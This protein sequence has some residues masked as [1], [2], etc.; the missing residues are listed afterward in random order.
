MRGG[1]RSASIDENMKVIGKPVGIKIDIPIVCVSGVR[2]MAFGIV[3]DD[4]ERRA[5]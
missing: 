4:G 3:E 2:H 5:R 1:D